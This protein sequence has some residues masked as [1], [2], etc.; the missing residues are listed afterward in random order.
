MI[1]DLRHNKPLSY[2]GSGIR[3]RTIQRF[4]RAKS[5]FNLRSFLQMPR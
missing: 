5:N 4:A 3:S 1:V 2:T